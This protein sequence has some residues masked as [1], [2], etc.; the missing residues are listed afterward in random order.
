M[1]RCCS[2]WHNYKPSDDFIRPQKKTYNK[3]CI[4]CRNIAY[5]SRCNK[6]LRPKD[7]VILNPFAVDVS[8]PTLNPIEGRIPPVKAHLKTRCDVK[9]EEVA[10]DF[11]EYII[12]DIDEHSFCECADYQKDHIK[13]FVI[14]DI[15]YFSHTKSL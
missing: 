9:E 11:Y 6:E 2:K 1:S 12:D 8:N 14:D 5:K 13:E 10:H 4:S 7:V 15:R 3:L